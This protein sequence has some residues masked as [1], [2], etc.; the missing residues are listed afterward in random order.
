[1]KT[2]EQA[3]IDKGISITAIAKHLGVSRHT[4]RAYEKNQDSM[5]IG[6]AR[7]ACEFIGVPIDEIFLPRNVN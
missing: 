7:A 2:I 4:Y 6:K 1:M 3:R 5:S